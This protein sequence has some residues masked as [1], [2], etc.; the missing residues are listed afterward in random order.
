MATGARDNS[1]VDP[2]DSRSSAGV[3]FV[4]RYAL[5]GKLASGGMATVHV[6]RLLGPVGFTRMVSIKRLHPE[7]ARDPEFVSMFLDEARLAA[8]I[9]HPNVVSTLDVVATGGELFLVMEYI[10]GQSLSWLVKN[11][12]KTGHAIPPRIVA[13]IGSGCLQGLHAAHEARD[14]RGVKLNIVHRDVSPQN[15]MVGA[16]GLARVLDFGVAKAAGRIQ[17]TREGHIKG[18]LAY[19]PPEQLQTDFI[20]RQA[21]I[22]ATSVMLWE[23]LTSTRLF[24]GETEG[25]TLAKIL[26][27]P[28]P[29]PSE[30]ASWVPAAFDAVI[31]K[32]LERDASMRYQTAREMAGALERCGNAASCAEVSDW[33]EQVAKRELD[34]RAA[35]IAALEMGAGLNTNQGMEALAR[36]LSAATPAFEDESASSSVIRHAK[37]A[38]A[39]TTPAAFTPPGTPPGAPP[40]APPAQAGSAGSTPPDESETVAL[41]TTGINLRVGGDPT[42]ETL[43]DAHTGDN[44]SQL[45]SVSV[46]LARRSLPG[47]RSRGTLLGAAL[48]GAA[49]AFTV[50]GL[51]MTG[52]GT[53]RTSPNAAAAPTSVRVPPAPEPAA[54][55]AVAPPVVAESVDTAA[56]V[57]LGEMPS[58][59][60]APTRMAVDVGALEKNR[61]TPRD[62]RRPP[63]RKTTAKPSSPFDSLGGRD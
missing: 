32:G 63:A 8:K 16:D 25:A 37:A 49:A 13:A 18:K 40:G 48:I 9:N 47:N 60:D 21:D 42:V 17:N 33:L 22:Y 29:R 46:A 30:A 34:D 26:S 36:A 44:A 57:T 19:M 7:Y 11:A 27:G 58:Q 62:V 20:T 50:A 51:W 52:A 31:M 41:N 1:N 45:S 23:A 43:G 61:T 5:L 28:V 6:G 12:A 54:A 10:H 2:A 59:P 53:T 3:R 15:V 14:E 38:T 24:K 35:R 55:P 4:G 39:D 56:S